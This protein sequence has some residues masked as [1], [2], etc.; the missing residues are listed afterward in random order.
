MCTSQN[1]QGN[2]PCTRQ[3]ARLLSWVLW[4]YDALKAQF[5]PLLPCEMSQM[6]FDRGKTLPRG[7]HFKGSQ[8]ATHQLVWSRRLPLFSEVLWTPSHLTASYLWQSSS[9]SCWQL[10][11]ARECLPHATEKQAMRSEFAKREDLRELCS[12]WELHWG[13]SHQLVVAEPP[14]SPSSVPLCCK[15]ELVPWVGI[16]FFLNNFF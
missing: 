10:L 9:S 12:G 3:T 7:Y 11:T 4:R 8:D 16:L 14:Q 13:V 6:F 2:P 5:S 1:C 15:V